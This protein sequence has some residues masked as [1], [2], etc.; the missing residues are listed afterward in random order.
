MRV[1]SDL[2]TRTLANAL[3]FLGKKIF[4]NQKDWIG[5]TN[6]LTNE[7]FVGIVRN[8]RLSRIN[9]NRNL[10]WH[11][12]VVTHCLENKFKELYLIGNLS[13][14]CFCPFLSHSKDNEF[15]SLITGLIKLRFYLDLVPWQAAKYTM[16]V[17]CCLRCESRNIFFF[18]CFKT[19]HDVLNLKILPDKFFSYIVD[20]L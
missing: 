2:F 13:A 11:I 9:L 10:D 17:V 14:W 6:H 5:Q 8:W 3:F 18:L 7:P 15:T 12:L 20:H 19:T 4:L 16:H 1:T